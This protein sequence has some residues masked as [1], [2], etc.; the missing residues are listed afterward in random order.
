M[1]TTA[2]C[3]AGIIVVVNSTIRQSA[4]AALVRKF[5]WSGG[6]ADFAPVFGDGEVLALLGPALADPWIDDGVTAVV[7]L[8]ARG[9]VLGAL[10]AERL[11]VGLVLARKPGSVHPGPKVEVVSAPDWRGRE[12]TIR[13]ARVLTRSDRT[14]LVDDWIETGSQARAVKEAVQLCGAVFVGTSVIV[15]DTT[16]DV[17]SSLN[18]V[19]LITAREL[20]K[21]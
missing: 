19:A 20:R 8:E 9:F 2:S 11:G 6:H 21:R 4:R 17:R 1:P 14:L 18:T 3:R 16:D 12:V 7:A 15:D 10:C 5:Q 13:L